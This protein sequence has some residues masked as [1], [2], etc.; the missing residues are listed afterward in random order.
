MI[1]YD[2]EHSVDIAD[3]GI[4][5]PIIGE[6]KSERV[7]RELMNLL[8][9]GDSGRKLKII[10]DIGRGELTPADLE[11]VHGK[12]HSDRFYKTDDIIF[13]AYELI[14]DGEYNR[15]DPEKAKK[16]L[17]ELKRYNIDNVAGT[18]QC[19]RLAA[20]KGF[21]HF[22]GGGMHHAHR[23]FVHGFCP[24][25]DIVVGIRG[26]QARGEIQS[27]WVIDTD[28]HKGDGTADLTKDDRTIITLSIHMAEGWPLTLPAALPDGSPHPAHISGDIDIPVRKK[29]NR[30]YNQLLEKGL[31]SLSQKPLPDIAVVVA[32]A[33]PYEHDEL[34]STETLNLTLDEM[35]RRDEMVYSFLKER[36]IP[37]AWLTAGG[38]GRRSWEVYYNFLKDLPEI[39]S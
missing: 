6:M 37:Q 39:I 11:R 18:M 9:S 16:P 36:N 20:I 35:K 3:F 22:L 28:A 33:D 19:I 12:E 31:E 24:L 1:L 29:E 15:Y 7:I 23:T 38:Y 14:V 32:G 10:S 5:I 34:P 25:N 13:E 17:S 30:L 27:A 26:A 21:C 8:S 2:K 4:D